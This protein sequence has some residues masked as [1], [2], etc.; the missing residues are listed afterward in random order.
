[1]QQG[2]V[3]SR[4]YRGAGSSSLAGRQGMY[5]SVRRK[6]CGVVAVL[7]CREATRLQGS[8][9]EQACRGQREIV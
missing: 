3:I 9:Q 5:Q 8:E 1:M 4:G 6:V 7:Q 2:P